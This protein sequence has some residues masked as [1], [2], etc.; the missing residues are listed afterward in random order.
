MTLKITPPADAG[1]SLYFHHGNVNVH[2][3][4]KHEISNPGDSFECDLC[5][6]SIRESQEA[7]PDNFVGWKVEGA[8][9]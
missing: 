2:P 1:L 9:G 6:A 5:G 7:N 4:H 3:D 8:I